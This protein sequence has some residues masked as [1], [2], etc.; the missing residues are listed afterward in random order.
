MEINYP[1]ISIVT[2]TYNSEAK[3][4]IALNSIAKQTYKNIEHIINDSF[5]TDKTVEI[6]NKYIE[7]NKD[8]YK[9]VFIQTEPKGIARALNDGLK[10]ATGD[11]VHFLHS[12]VYYYNED[13]LQK[14]ANY[15]TQDSSLE[16]LIGN[17]VFEIKE[18]IKTIRETKIATINPEKYIK[19]RGPIHHENTFVKTQLVRDFGAFD[20]GHKLA[21]EQRLWIRMSRVKVPKFVDENFAVS[22]SHEGSATT[23]SIGSLLMGAIDGCGVIVEEV[24]LNKEKEKLI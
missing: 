21:V 11:V 22:I 12:D 10:L 4:K 20:E 1:K 2:C 17:F 8:K 23:K 9:I 14:V 16:W 19:W 13:T 15:F 6:I 18:K 5:S 24:I 3:L 7:E